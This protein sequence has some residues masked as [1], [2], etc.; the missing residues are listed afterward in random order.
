MDKYNLEIDLQ[1]YPIL[2]KINKDYL[3]TVI[4]DIF[5]NGYNSYVRNQIIN[6]EIIN[7]INTNNITENKTSS[8]KGQLGENIVYEI[9][10]ERFQDH[11]IENTSKVP[12]SGDIQITLKNQNKVIVE[13]KNY[14]KTIDQGE[15][16]KMRF[17]MKFNNIYYGIFLSLNSGIVGKKRFEIETFYYNKANYYILYVPYAMHKII[18]T[19]KYTITHNNIDDGLINLTIKVEFC[20][21]II[22]NLTTNII[23][24][25]TNIIKYYNLDNHID[26][27]ISQLN[28]FYEEFN[29][30]KQS[31]IKLEENVK[32]SIDNHLN[33]IKEYEFSIKNNINRLLGTKM[34]SNIICRNDLS[35]IF[36]ILKINKFTW[37]IQINNI[38]YGKIVKIDDLYDIFININDVS[39]NEQYESY[40]E[41]VTSINHIINTNFSL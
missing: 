9:L 19:R 20:V 22:S 13:V 34:Q 36:N 23:K 29:S 10:V 12:H 24:Q 8:S 4:L 17:D 32:K 28:K 26:Y 33:V 6:T 31:A 35:N 5:N 11:C 30:L 40:E 3:D 21:C 16:E 1:K 14:N 27:V 39:Y 18:P 2:N 37:D 15:L 41:C 7:T 25:N 38:I